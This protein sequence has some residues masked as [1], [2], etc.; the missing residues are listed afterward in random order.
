MFSKFQMTGGIFN[1]VSIL[2]EI[3]WIKI[4]VWELKKDTDEVY[5]GIFIQ[6]LLY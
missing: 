1:K 3:S 4:E 2:Q 6:I 5:Y